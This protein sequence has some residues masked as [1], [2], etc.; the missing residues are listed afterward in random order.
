MALK[1]LRA[2]PENGELWRGRVPPAVP[3]ETDAK[4]FDPRGELDV[5]QFG[6]ARCGQLAGGRT[7]SVLYGELGGGV[8]MSDAQLEAW[9]L[10]HQA[11]VSSGTEAIKA[12]LLI[13][14]GAVTGVLAFMAALVGQG[15]ICKSELN[16]LVGSLTMFGWGLAIAALAICLAYVTNRVILE[17]VL[18]PT[19]GWKRLSIATQIISV[20]AAA[21]SLAV[22]LF[23]AAEV[24]ESILNMQLITPPARCS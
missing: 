14:G 7:L 21:A 10:N 24:K 19:T 1:T 15:R 8:N 13:N 17:S 11:S 12:L 6:G 18:S 2:P 4:R 16:S 5:E 22:F 20:F 23:G 3:V 9:K